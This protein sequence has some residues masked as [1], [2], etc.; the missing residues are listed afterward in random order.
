MPLLYI[1]DNV[2]FRD[3]NFHMLCNL[4][5]RICFLM[6]TDNFLGFNGFYY[7][8]DGGLVGMAGGVDIHN[9]MEHIAEIL[10]FGIGLHLLRN[11]VVA[12]PG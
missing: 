9:I 10:V 6:D 4:Y 5:F 3:F 1:G 7:F 2:P 12:I 8:L 11:L